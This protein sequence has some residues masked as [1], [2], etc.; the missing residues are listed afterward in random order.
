MNI[1]RLKGV[2]TQLK[3]IADCFEVYIYETY[4]IRM[5]KPTTTFGADESDVDYSTDMGTL[6]NELVNIRSGRKPD[7][8]GDE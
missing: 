2:E 5:S 6:R 3:R 4:K 8:M 1:F 7:D